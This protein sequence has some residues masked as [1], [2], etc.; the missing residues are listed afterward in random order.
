MKNLHLF[1]IPN[2]GHSSYVTRWHSVSCHRYQ[3]IADHSFKVTMYARYLGSLVAPDMNDHDKLLMTDL[4]LLHDLPEVKTG[5][6]ATPMKRY[7][8]SRFPKGESPI[9]FMEEKLCAPYADIRSKT[10]GSYIAVIAKLADI[11]DAIH[12]ITLEGKGKAAAKIQR[13]RHKAFQDYIRIGV[14]GWPEYNWYAANELLD[15]LL[16]DEPEQIDFEEIVTELTPLQKE[17][18]AIQ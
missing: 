7:L 17:D 11:M 12:F 10:K 14:T 16:N 15:S 5:D 8:E 3:T 2:V 9:D 18:T 13:E 4:C 1:P 6:I